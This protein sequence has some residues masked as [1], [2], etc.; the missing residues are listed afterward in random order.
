LETGSAARDL[1][2]GDRDGRARGSFPSS[3]GENTVMGALPAAAGGCHAE[4]GGHRSER[5]TGPDRLARGPRLPKHWFGDGEVVY[6][7][8]VG[9][10]VGVAIR[11]AA[12]LVGGRSEAL[13]RGDPGGQG[14]VVIS[15]ERICRTM[16]GRLITARIF[17]FPPQRE[18]TSR[19]T[20]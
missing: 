14:F 9:P 11:Q 8:Y 5:G 16:A 6:D 2:S 20:S 4:S 18:Q 10:L 3:R 17:V 19:S 1:G 13:R 15:A 12:G 7:G